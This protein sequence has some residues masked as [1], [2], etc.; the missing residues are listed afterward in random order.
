LAKG[1]AADTRAF[2]TALAARYI[3]IKAAVNSREWDK[4]DNVP[5]S[6]TAHLQTLVDKLS[7]EAEILEELSDEKARAALQMEFNELEARMRLAK[8][9]AAVL[10]AILRLDR[11][12]RLTMCLSAV[13]TNAISLKAADLTEKVVSKDL[14]TALNN[15]FKIL[16]VG[17]DAGRYIERRGAASHRHWFF[18]GGSQRWGWLWR[19]CFR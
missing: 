11:Q 1:L 5:P 14:A 18:S 8:V 4:V 2:E 10:A 7:Q 6:P 9:K 13:K 12:S 3:A 19:D 17:E 15:E 16:G